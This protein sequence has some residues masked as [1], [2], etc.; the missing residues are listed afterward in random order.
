[1]AAKSWN[2][3]FDEISNLTDSN[4][5]NAWKTALAV[6]KIWNDQRF[7]NE[8]DHR[9]DKMEAKLSVLTSRFC[10]NVLD[11]MGLIEWFP[12]QGDWEG[13]DL[14]W[15]KNEVIRLEKEKSE[16]KNDDGDGSDDSRERP[17]MSEIR[18][19]RAEV[20]QL[21]R[22]VSKWKKRSALAEKKLAELELVS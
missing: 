13:G 21:K 2:R 12:K 7:R 5:V 15:L 20:K 8:F 6:R 4:G 3:L 16:S 18:K 1:M 10:L 22:E 17:T 14:L 9:H 19:L 11:M